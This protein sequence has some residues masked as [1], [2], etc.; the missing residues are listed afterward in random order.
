MSGLFPGAPKAA[1]IPFTDA[2][3]R[4][5]AGA[6]AEADR[7]RHEYVGAEHVVFAMTREV[8]AASLLTR[9]GV[10]AMQVRATLETAVTPGHATLA[11]GTGRPYTSRTRQAFGLAA[12]SASAAGHTA[13]GVEH[14]V[15]G[16]MREQMNIGAQVLQHHGLSA[17]RVAA[18][19]PRG[20]TGE[21]V[22]S[23]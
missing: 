12:E 22:S 21:N 5:L 20:R 10:D 9:L 13:V 15:L 1:D 8:D 17:E 2:A 14:V 7:L 11:P 19:V 18:E 3:R 6:E 4:L 23:P 16:L